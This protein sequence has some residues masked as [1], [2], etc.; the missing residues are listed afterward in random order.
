VTAKKTKGRGKSKPKVAVA[1]KNAEKAKKGMDIAEVRENI[2]ELVK[3]SANDIAISVIELTT[4]TGQLSSAKYLFEAVGI[5]PP[6]EQAEAR[7]LE[8]SM[9]HQLLTRL[10]IP[11]EPVVREENG[12]TIIREVTLVDQPALVKEKNPER[13]SVEENSNGAD[14][15]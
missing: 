4:R 13:K 14:E 6:S 1:E 12:E 11:I 8:M 9:A 2:S 5:Y 7:P 10:G 3:A 15:S